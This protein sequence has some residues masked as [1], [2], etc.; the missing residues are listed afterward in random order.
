MKNI[1]ELVLLSTLFLPLSFPSPAWAGS[2]S[3]DLLVESNENSG[4][5][6]CPNNV[7]S[8]TPCPFLNAL[9]RNG[10]ISS[11]E[12]SIDELVNAAMKYGMNPKLMETLASAV[13]EPNGSRKVK[14]S[15]LLDPNHRPAH[16]GSLARS[17]GKLDTV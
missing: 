6:T 9:I 17:D 10:T 11:E 13:S 8:F 1:K 5:A 16:L 14:L 4:L 2:D 12:P 15:K 3:C 7:T